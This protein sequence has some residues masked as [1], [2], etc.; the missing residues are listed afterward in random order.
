MRECKEWKVSPTA[1]GKTKKVCARYEQTPD[2]ALVPENEDSNANMGIVVPQPLKGLGQLSGKD[3]MGP[4]VGL[5]GTGLGAV[6]ARKYGDK[7][8]EVVSE[9]YG[10][11]GAA[12]GV[13]ASMALY[14]TGGKKQMMTGAVSSVMLGLGVQFIPQL[15]EK[16]STS[17]YAGLGLVTAEPVGMMPQI[18]DAG[19]APSAVYAQ[20]DVSAWGRVG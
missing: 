9:Y 2:V 16:F 15:A 14:Y 3:F 1:T 17:D 12:F 6:L 18:Q 10:L 20:T 5:L 19:S 4:S 8:H 7:I 13:L 11:F